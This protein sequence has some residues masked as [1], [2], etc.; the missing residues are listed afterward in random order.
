MYTLPAKTDIL[1]AI[2]CATAFPT[3]SFWLT[4]TGTKPL[5]DGTTTDELITTRIQLPRD[6]V[7]FLVNS[8]GSVSLNIAVMFEALG[9]NATIRY[10]VLMY[11][12]I[13][14][15]C[16]ACTDDL[17][18]PMTAGDQPNYEAGDLTF[19]LLNDGE[20]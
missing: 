10:A 13:G 9:G 7:T 11:T 1:G 8:D 14:G 19:R 17:N 12:Q 18:F 5:D 6:S 20:V 16:F 2:F 15:N 3:A 4:L